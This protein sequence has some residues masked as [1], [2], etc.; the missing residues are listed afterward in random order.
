MSQPEYSF[1]AP[2]FI[3]FQALHE[4]YDNNADSWFDHMVD[5]ENVPPQDRQTVRQQSR[6]PVSKGN[7][8][9]AV[10]TPLMKSEENHNSD[11]QPTKPNDNIATSAA[12]WPIASKRVPVAEVTNSNQP[13]RA[14]R[15][16]SLEQKKKKLAKI[17]DERRTVTTPS[18][19]GH[20]TATVEGHP[21]IKKQKLVIKGSERK[22]V[23]RP[24]QL[25]RLQ[26]RGTLAE[27]SLN[28]GPV[29]DCISAKPK[30]RIPIPVTP[31][32]MKRK[33][34]NTKL[35]S[36]EEQE[37]EKMQQLQ[38]EVMEQRRKNE[39]SLRAAIAGQPLKKTSGQITRP[40]DFHFRTDDRLKR[41]PESQPADEF[42][43]VDFTAALRR[44]PPSPARIPKGGHTVPKPFNLSQ[45]NKRKL[46]EEVAEPCKFVSTA[47][48]VEAFHKNTPSRYH[49]RSRQ[50]NEGPGP[51]PIKCMK[52]KL[53][54][55]KTPQLETKRRH[56]PVT[57]KSTA[58]LEAE[59]LD[60]IQQ[61]KFR[62]QELDPRVLDGGL[63]L[64]KMQSVKEPT[65]PI[66]FN[67]ELEKRIQEREAKKE[68]PEEERF[69]FHSRPCPTKMLEEVVGVPEKICL[70]PTV[71]KSPAFALK[72]RVRRPALEEEQEE[73]PVIKA[74]PMPHY[75][76]PFKPKIQEQKTVEPAPFSFDSRDQE[77]R[78]QKE[79][80][81]E[82]LRKEE[83]PTFKALPLPHFDQ[84]SLPEKKVKT[85]TNPQPFHLQI[86][87]RAAK[88][89]QR[90]KQQI[91]EELRQ[92]KEAACFKAR[93]NTVIHQEPFV[94][95]K[96]S[97][98]LSESLSGSIVQESFE[99]ATEKRAKERQE[100]EKRLAELEA[101]KE[102]IQE[103]E[104]IRKQEHE[105]EEL[106]QRRHDLVHKA[107]PV[108]K[109]KP[110][111][112]KAS[113]VPLTVPKSPNFSDRFQ[114]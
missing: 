57:C 108:R 23:F 105:K 76:V 44:H 28:K 96:D 89:S 30:A 70:A 65:K 11:V 88:K 42:K 102:K 106:A 55:P 83:V 61:Y 103:E 49:L 58:E 47:Q 8:P 18:A 101:I 3:N 15:R 75:G 112:V 27:M 73:A 84:V 77:R 51:S 85:V 16:L 26:S 62:A 90:W 59:E 2:N 114:C 20:S 100:F 7:V 39:E 92:Q 109:Y 38:Q 63:V 69:T 99:L 29:G 22:T 31:M 110:V 43:E 52:T 111:E 98:V 81:L 21:P 37:V 41:H 72:Y 64:P 40:V 1:D 95:K 13:K 82:E 17:R 10:V 45:S 97:R 33:H 60:K 46:D 78:A 107:Q 93:P 53:T 14:S 56:R 9:R 34:L 79:K 35:K 104:H 5:A 12:G 68:E 19:E 54:N 113:V 4:Q 91:E 67:L 32:V 80:K 48:Q 94:P 86:E 87:E 71:P 66:G 36:T 6:T 24:Q 74:N 50:Q 25:R